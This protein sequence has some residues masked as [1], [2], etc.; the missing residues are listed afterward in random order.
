MDP[1]SRK[2]VPRSGNAVSGIIL[3]S[4]RGPCIQAMN[5]R[6]GAQVRGEIAI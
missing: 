1:E 3:S 2:M 6:D 4:V 5:F